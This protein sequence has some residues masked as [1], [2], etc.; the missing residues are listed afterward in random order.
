MFPDVGGGTL[1]TSPNIS[2]QSKKCPHRF[3]HRP[4]WRKHFLNW[5]SSSQVT[6]A[7]INLTKKNNNNNQDILDFIIYANST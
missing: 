4:T 1:P 6:L 2:H 5:S 7:Y 3:A